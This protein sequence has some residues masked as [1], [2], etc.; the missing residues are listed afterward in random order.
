[1][2]LIRVV[3][4]QYGIARV[5]IH[6]VHLNFLIILNIVWMMCFFQKFELLIKICLVYYIE[7]SALFKF[8]NTTFILSGLGQV[9]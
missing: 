8:L 3:T 5:S 4:K 6:C 2:G 9:H 7:F 1:M